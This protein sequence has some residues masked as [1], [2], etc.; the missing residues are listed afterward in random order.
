MPEIWSLANKRYTPGN[1]L[2][3]TGSEKY[4][5]QPS[6]HTRSGTGDDSNPSSQKWSQVPSDLTSSFPSLSFPSPSRPTSPTHS[7]FHRRQPP[8]ETHHL[9]PLTTQQRNAP[10]PSATM[11]IFDASLPIQTRLGALASS[12]AINCLLPFINGVM[13]GFGE[14]FAKNVVVGWL[15]WK[16]PGSGITNVGVKSSGRR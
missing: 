7:H 13:L 4:L 2:L 5:Q 16:L 10:L 9:G 8:P 14:I 11:A 12:L 1:L 6:T 15:G 3:S